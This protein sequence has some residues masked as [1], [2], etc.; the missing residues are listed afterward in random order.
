VIL[1]VGEDI[2][3]VI[4]ILLSLFV[5]AIMLI[6][7]VLFLLVFGPRILRAWSRRRSKK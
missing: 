4:A 5:P 7:V 3:V 2:L 1:S 6:L